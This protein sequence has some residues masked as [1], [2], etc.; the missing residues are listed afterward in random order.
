MGKY[1]YILNISKNLLF[2]ELLISNIYIYIFIFVISNL[3]VYV[4]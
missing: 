1:L 3:E 4:L 2:V